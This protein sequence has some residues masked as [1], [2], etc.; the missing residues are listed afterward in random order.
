MH[1]SQA[2]KANTA[3][4]AIHFVSLP[5][6][7]QDRSSR[8]EFARIGRRADGL[9]GRQVAAMALV[10]VMFAGVL[11]VPLAGQTV[12]GVPTE[13]PKPTRTPAP[14]PGSAPAAVAPGRRAAAVRPPQPVESTPVDFFRQL[15]A[16]SGDERERLLA[17]RPAAQ[18]SQFRSILQEYERCSPEER[19]RRLLALELRYR[20]TTL[21]RLPPEG[22]AQAVARLSDAVR[23][24]VQERLA[25]WEQLAPDVQ[26]ALRDNE[27]LIRVVAYVSPGRMAGTPARGALGSNELGRIEAAVREWNNLPENRR[28]AAEEAFR[29]VFE[30]APKTPLTPAEQADMKRTLARFHQ[31][32]PARRNAVIRNAPKLAEMSPQERAAFLQSA[33]EWRQM[34]PEERTVWRNLVKR[35][36]VFPPFPPGFRALPPLP[37]PLPTVR[38]VIQASNHTHQGDANAGAENAR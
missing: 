22:R 23:P 19:E 2:T 33:E 27:R 12:P 16:A 7:T 25:Y 24:L 30:E 37:V 8:P 1:C 28:A 17:T 34:S 36:P 29:R 31:L 35:A 38:P 6:R 3:R 10:L 11:V 15:L 4:V 14:A 9:A 20:I 21:L 5:I 32:S 26:Q 18:H 13:V